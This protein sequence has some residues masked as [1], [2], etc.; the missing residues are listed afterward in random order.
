[1]AEYDPTKGKRT[2]KLL[3]A[4]LGFVL[5][6]AIVVPFA[7]RPQPAQALPGEA[8]A[9]AVWT[10]IK[11]KITK[12]IEIVRKNAADI[13]YK[14]AL[15]TYLTQFAQETA[16]RIT[17]SGPGQKPI[18]PSD[19]KYYLKFGDAAA[20]DF[21]DNLAKNS[22]GID[23]CK[24]LNLNQQFSIESAV[25]KLASKLDKFDPA[26][27]CNQEY[28]K[29]RTK[30]LFTV[31]AGIFQ[32][33]VVG[34]GPP[35]GL[36]LTLPDAEANLKKIRSNLSFFRQCQNPLDAAACP[37][38]LMQPECPFA[39]GTHSLGEC[40]SE[41]ER[42][43]STYKKKI[44]NDRR[45]CTEKTRTQP[46]IQRCSL[47]QAF[48][49]YKAL[50]SAEI[51]PE[52]TKYF[53]PG[54]NDI[55]TI[56]QL[57]DEAQ[58][59]AREAEQIERDVQ[60]FGTGPI[61]DTV[62]GKILTT[63]DLTGAA[64]EK[65]LTDDPSGDVNK[66]HTNSPLADARDV[67]LHTLIS[68]KASLTRKLLDYLFKKGVASPAQKTF[69]AGTLQTTSGAQAARAIISQLLQPDFTTGEGA[70][71]IDDLVACPDTEPGTNNC[72]I[73][74]GFRQAIEQG[75]TVREALEQGL[76]DG[77][78]PFGYKFTQS[79]YQDLDYRE[80]YP[81]RS[82]LILRRLRI[83]PVGWELAAQYIRDFEQHQVTL[84]QLA[85]AYSQCDAVAGTWSP[86]CGL[87]DPEWVLKAPQTFCAVSGATAQL[88]SD[89]YLPDPVYADAPQV[90]Q[91]GRAEACVDEKTC[92]REDD[93]GHC[94]SWGYCV[95]ERASW[96]FGGDQ[97]PGQYRSCET[98]A[99]EDGEAASYLTNTLNASGCSAANAGCQ[100]YC[101][102]E[103]SEG[104]FTCTSESGTKDYLTAK[105]RTC[106][107]EEAGCTQ[108]IRTTNT[109]NL[110]ANS[111][112][113]TRKAGDELDDGNADD[114]SA[115]GWQK[116]GT[117]TTEAVSDV[118]SGSA[119]LRIEGSAADELQA[120]FNTK[121]SLDG[122]A[123]NLSFF[124]KSAASSDCTGGA[125][126]IRGTSTDGVVQQGAAADFSTSWQR[127]TVSITFDPAKVYGEND[128]TVTAFVSVN[129]CPIVLDDVQLEYGTSFSQYTDYGTENLLYLNG[130][131]TSCEPENV[132]CD[133]Y[134]SATDQFP[135]VATAGD[136]CPSNQVGCRAFLEVAV[137]E[138][139]ANADFAERTGKRCSLDQSISCSSNADCGENGSCE[140][141]VSLVPST[142]TICSAA[143]V[144]CEEYTNLDEVA[145]GGEGKEYY[146][147]IRP[148]VKPG[149]DL[150]REKT[151]YTWIGNDQ[152][153]FQLQAYIL[154]SAPEVYQGDATGGGPAYINGSADQAVTKCTEAIFNNTGDPNWTPDCRQ[155]Y[156]AD[157]HVY[158][159][160]YARTITISDD[161]HPLR[162]TLDSAIYNAIPSEGTTCSAGEVQ[163]REYRGPSGFNTRIILSDTFDDAETTGWDSGGT[164]SATSLIFGGSSMSVASDATN[165]PYSVRTT[166]DYDVPHQVQEGRSYILTFWAAAES[167]SRSTITASFA[168][169]SEKFAGS[170][171]AKW[172]D[173][174]PEWN[175]FTL[176]PLHLQ[177]PADLATDDFDPMDDLQIVGTQP[178]YI[179]NVELQEVADSVY[180][181]KGSAALCAGNENC[182][183]YANRN[184]EPFFLKSFTRL[185]PADKVG[186][187][188]LV[189]TQN[190]DSPFS[191]SYANG[192][193]I[194]GTGDKTVP[195]DSVDLVINDAAKY[196]RQ[197]NQGCARYG[198]PTLGSAGYACSN[199]P[200]KQCDPANT[201]AVCG[202]GASCV[203]Q[204]IRIAEYEEAFLVNEPE[205][206]ETILCKAPDVGCNAWN[207][208]RTGETAYFR[209]PT[210]RTCE[211]R[212][213]LVNGE[214]LSGWYKTGTSG[215]DPADV[216]P[217]LASPAPAPA[218][219]ILPVSPYTQPTDRTCAKD[220]TRSCVADSDC[221]VGTT[222]YGP[223]ITWAGLCP[224]DQAG[225]TEY[226]DQSDPEGCF[227]SCLLTIDS[228]TGDTVPVNSSCQIQ[229]GTCSVTASQSCFRDSECPANE[230][231]N[232]TTGC[233]GYT[234]LAQSVEDDAAECNGV[235]NN[236][237]GC[238]TFYT[239]D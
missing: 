67:F 150:N 126:G 164:P 84:Q 173:G 211:Y 97:S 217:G 99:L 43:I 124:A 85:D 29:A 137:T 198:K 223:C 17:T 178:F 131:R 163:C 104:R 65:A 62:T 92:L 87:V 74:D 168:G 120:S 78:K 101:G 14:T 191:A 38:T 66:I 106:P 73:N 52:V 188:A 93:S 158:Y 86:Y 83:V 160:L 231:C 151:Y 94:L 140:P 24:P 152:T 130:E 75:L 60:T 165:P 125:F 19:P 139:G 112:F 102:D 181:T 45:I 44:D 166:S 123:F 115:L 108:Y 46:R 236:D 4:I 117:L 22:F 105:T 9:A 95:Q 39:A 90:R 156:D 143:S 118:N 47:S 69:V 190:S 63:G 144:G 96:K 33:G 207:N 148:C 109:S 136:V 58:E 135:A 51:L 7:F 128:T 209:D 201:V 34:V 68:R 57:E 21:L 203:F 199:D 184:G 224:D 129:S 31:G 232:K 79:G 71:G 64:A 174:L 80:G 172:G 41:Y 235:A 32:V 177:R 127:Y 215:L 98:Y 162:N 149:E 182:D 1:M 205:E 192:S 202:E 161:C 153:G 208:Q 48:D 55:G 185:C 189:N 226:R 134:T 179:D 49:N 221:A 195:A 194:N 237:L 30:G 187:E 36:Q 132:G 16:I 233:R 154:Q 10:Y 197:E 114:F 230:T 59:L 56:F 145:K 159:R 225:C 116:T 76:L 138:N 142:G 15:R 133:L 119:A 170:A 103:D 204:D 210:P 141:S 176:G 169:G 167:E 175:F 5:V 42:D 180:L 196:C 186:C 216:C 183:Q 53:E 213:L 111:G 89:D 2:V 100:W 23:V 70:T 20:G 206:Y 40:V 18:F 81:Y 88:T 3:S 11:T 193:D 238:R 77:S 146:T 12:G 8:M 227:S 113:E 72:V 13:A 218:N 157:L 220:A 222:D 110:L 234:Y 91:I 122:Q 28:D 239:P 37:S 212:T 171:E 200:T 27:R 6:I 155:F 214:S 121:T 61:R 25:N 54:E 147:Y 26:N 219:D 50:G 82:S 107:A 228:I 35:G 229:L